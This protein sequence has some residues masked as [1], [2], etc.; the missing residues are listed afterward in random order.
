[1]AQ[2]RLKICFVSFSNINNGTAKRALELARQLSKKHDVSI[3]FD[4]AESNCVPKKFGKLNIRFGPFLKT[5]YITL[6]FGMLYKAMQM[7]RDYDIIYCLKP[8]PTSFIPSKILAVLSGAKLVVDWDD[9][10]GKGGLAE[11]DPY[12]L[13]K[14]IQWFEE[15]GIRKADSVTAIS[16]PLENMARTMNGKVA[17][18]E[19]GVDCE[20]FSLGNRKKGKSIVFVGSLQKTCELDFL[21]DSIE[22]PEGF[23]LNVIG[24]GSRKKEFAELAKK[25]GIEN[26]VVFAGELSQE[27]V[28]KQI[29]EAWAAVLPLKDT[30]ANRARSPIKLGEY[31]AC[32]KII[33]A[34]S[35][36]P[37]KKIIQHGRNGLFFS[38]PGEFTVLF[39]EMQDK[40][41]A[42]AIQRNARK[43][44]LKMGWRKEAEKLESFYY[45]TINKA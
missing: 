45:S 9:L 15:Y 44:A 20:F 16:E 36:G 26:R 25:K 4:G 22:L 6:A 40:K 2:K 32:G 14:V 3:L 37:I 8:L 21:M 24:G 5:H 29:Q 27:E 31:A 42:S 30:P 1:M 43:T 18:V 35:V 38:G 12:P 39:R 41:K 13:K 28:K 10:E 11:K 19:N 34:N 7:K 23:K 17:V 33:F